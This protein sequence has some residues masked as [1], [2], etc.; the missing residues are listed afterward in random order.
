MLDSL[1]FVRRSLAGTAEVADEPSSGLPALEPRALRCTSAAPE[2]DLTPEGSGVAPSG[3]P[4]LPARHPS[5]RSAAY[6]LLAWPDA[7]AEAGAPPTGLESPPDALLIV[8][9]CQHSIVGA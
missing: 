8:E 3:H 2:T 9:P 6:R 1:F 4:L 7:E 5:G